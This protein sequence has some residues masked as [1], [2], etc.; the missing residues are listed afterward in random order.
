[1]LWET[2]HGIHWDGPRIVSKNYGFSFHGLAQGIYCGTLFE[3]TISK[4]D[5]NSLRARI[6]LIHQR[7]LLAF[8]LFIFLVDANSVYADP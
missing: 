8:L 1:M 2:E 3:Y 4:P 7:Y 5:V 6:Y